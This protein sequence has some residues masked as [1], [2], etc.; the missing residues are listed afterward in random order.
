[1]RLGKID[2]RQSDQGLHRDND[3]ARSN[4]SREKENNIPVFA[5]CHPYVFADIVPSM[6]RQEDSGGFSTE[7]PTLDPQALIRH[8][9][10]ARRV[11]EGFRLYPTL[12][13][14]P[15]ADVTAPLAHASG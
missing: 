7:F 2:E 3:A 4:F 11:S 12:A 8:R 1:L 15:A 10:L 14:E 5:F 6:Q 13:V 9:L